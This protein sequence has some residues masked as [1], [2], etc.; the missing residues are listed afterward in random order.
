MGYARGN[1]IDLATVVNTFGLK[2]ASVTDYARKT[3]CN[4]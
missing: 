1:A 3:L 2:L 4:L